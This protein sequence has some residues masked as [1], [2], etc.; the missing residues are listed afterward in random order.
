[1][2]HS[3]VEIFEGFELLLYTMWSTHGMSHAHLRD[4]EGMYDM[5]LAAL[6]PCFFIIVLSTLVC[7]YR[8]MTSIEPDVKSVQSDIEWIHHE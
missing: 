1:M 8:S 5:S 3:F 7:S 4:M 6:Q 2:I